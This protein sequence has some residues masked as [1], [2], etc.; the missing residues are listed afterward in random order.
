MSLSKPIVTTA[1]GLVKGLNGELHLNLETKWSWQWQ[2]EREDYVRT[3]NLEASIRMVEWLPI[4]HVL[5]FYNA[6]NTM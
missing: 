3:E 1:M 6:F 5:H 4:D 2:E